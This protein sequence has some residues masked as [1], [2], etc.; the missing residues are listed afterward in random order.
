MGCTHTYDPEVENTWDVDIKLSFVDP[1]FW[2][3]DQ[4]VYIG[5]FNEESSKVPVAKVSIA[6]P[7]DVNSFSVSLNEIDEGG[8]SA[9]LYLTENGVYKVSI[10]DFGT[11]EVYDDLIKEVDPIQLISFD[12]VQRQVLNNCIVCHGGSSGD[13]AAEL[14]LTSGS[15]YEN[16]VGV[17]SYMESELYRV[18]AGSSSYSYLLKVLNKDIDFDHAASSSATEADRQLIIDWIDQGALNN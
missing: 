9:K 15:S 12:R 3:E 14:N 13:V 1:E 10:A 7:S 18:Y 11:Y 2:P 5:L 6:E 8:Y 16:L 4:R 17:K